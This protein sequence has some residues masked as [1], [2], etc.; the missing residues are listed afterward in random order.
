MFYITAVVRNRVNFLNTPGLKQNQTKGFGN[1]GASLQDVIFSIGKNPSGK[2]NI[3]TQF[4]GFNPDGS[5]SSSIRNRINNALDSDSES[6]E[7]NALRFASIVA[8]IPNA[9]LTSIGELNKV[10]GWV[11]RDTKPPGGDFYALQQIHGSGNTFY[12]LK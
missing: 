6:G 5:I 1:V 12:G 11:T 2:S 8:S 10:F 4:Q 9:E 3:S 7:C